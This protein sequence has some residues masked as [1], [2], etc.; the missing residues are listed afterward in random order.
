MWTH[1]DRERGVKTGFFCGRHKWMAPKES[2]QMLDACYRRAKS[3]IQ[4]EDWGWH[5]GWQPRLRNLRSGHAISYWGRWDTEVDGISYW[6]RWAT[7]VD[8]I[9]LFVEQPILRWS[10][11]GAAGMVTSWGSGPPIFHNRERI[12]LLDTFPHLR[13]VLSSCDNLEVHLPLLW[14]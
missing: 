14:S 5:W 8:G 2:F 11:H 6:G 1:V 9:K 13:C 4:V 3:E 7:E 10:L 12:G